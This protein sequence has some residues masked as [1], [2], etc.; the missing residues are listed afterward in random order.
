M[1]E[2]LLFSRGF[3][4]ITNFDT[5]PICSLNDSLSSRI[6]PRFFAECTNLI[7]SLFMNAPCVFMVCFSE[8]GVTINIF[9]LLEFSRRN[10][11]FIH[12]AISLKQ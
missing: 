3:L 8:G 1:K 10:K 12:S 5:L 4:I 2:S 9:V 11:L 7:H 6:T